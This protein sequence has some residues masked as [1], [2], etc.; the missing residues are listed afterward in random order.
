M[1]AVQSWSGNDFLSWT[2]FHYADPTHG[3][4][5]YVSK[6]VAQSSNLVGLNNGQFQMSIAGGAPVN[7]SRNSVRISSPANWKKGQLLVGDF[8]HLPEGCGTWPAFWSIGA[9]RAWPAG[10]EIDILEG[11]NSSPG[12]TYTLHTTAG[13]SATNSAGASTMLLTKDC[14]YQPGCSYKDTD[15]KSYGPSFNQAGGGVYAAFFDDSGIKI[16][17][18]S[19]ANVPASVSAGSPDMSTFGNPKAAWSSSSCTLDQFFDAEQMI[20]INTTLMGDWAGATFWDN[21][22]TGTLADAMNNANNVANAYW[23]IN[24]VKIYQ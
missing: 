13:C 24:S 1:K 2:F 9:K 15:A 18:W 14:Q 7:G 12:N 17:F 19:R 5:N 6:D 8:A 3:N 11:V 4:V 23:L 16:W 20:I 10:G 21:G 22:C